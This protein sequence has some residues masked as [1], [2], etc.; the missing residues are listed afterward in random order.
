MVDAAFKDKAV[1]VYRD[2]A[3]LP[4]IEEAR[5]TAS[6]TNNVHQVELKWKQKDIDRGKNVGFAKSYLVQKNDQTELQL[7]T[8]VSFQRDTTSV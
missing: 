5:I 1:K 8:E 3:Q 7:L 4:F 6:P 2:I